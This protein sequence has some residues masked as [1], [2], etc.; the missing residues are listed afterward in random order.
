MATANDLALS[1]LIHEIRGQKVMLDEDL[2]EVYGT[3]TKALNQAIKRNV[4]RFPPD[5]A[6]QLTRQEVTTLRSQ[7]VTS[8]GSADGAIFLTRSPSTARSWPRM[9]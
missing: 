2:A 8:K 9:S 3:T 1:R 6:F 5:F 4:H 7:F